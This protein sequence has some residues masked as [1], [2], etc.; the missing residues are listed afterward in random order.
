MAD[1]LLQ[2]D[3]SFQRTKVRNAFDVIAKRLNPAGL[4][5]L[6]STGKPAAPVLPA[7]LFNIG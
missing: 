1:S 4:S 2:V 7:G 6:L 3:E 5:E